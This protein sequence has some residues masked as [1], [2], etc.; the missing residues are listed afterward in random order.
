ML[1]RIGDWTP[2]GAAVDAIQQALQTGFPSATH[3]LVLT[4]Y[5]LVSGALA[6]RFFRWE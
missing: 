2:T 4:G 6:I 5:A 3:L 1:I